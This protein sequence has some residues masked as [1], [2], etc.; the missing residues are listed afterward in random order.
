MLWYIAVAAFNTCVQVSGNDFYLV[1]MQP[2]HKKLLC[3][4]LQRGISLVD[5]DLC[6]NSCE[7]TGVLLCYLRAP[8][9]KVIQRCG[10]LAHI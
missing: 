9:V 6:S 8:L 2:L 1:R 3:E 10:G 4:V 5:V 7:I